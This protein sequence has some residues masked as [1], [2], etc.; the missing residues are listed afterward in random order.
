MRCWVL[1][2][3]HEHHSFIR[4]YCPRLWIKYGGANSLW[5][6]ECSLKTVRSIF[7]RNFLQLQVFQP[8]SSERL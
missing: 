4:F 7:L 5:N 1:P 6:I 8:A 3:E 2:C